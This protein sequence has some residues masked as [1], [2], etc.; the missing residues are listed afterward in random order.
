MSQATVVGHIAPATVER[1]TDAPA[2]MGTGGLMSK[3][4]YAPSADLFRPYFLFANSA[5]SLSS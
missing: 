5:S 4:L 2:E 3:A 1:R